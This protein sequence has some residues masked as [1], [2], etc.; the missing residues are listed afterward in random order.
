VS[1]L[2]IGALGSAATISPISGLGSAA[3]LAGSAA[4]TASSFGGALTQ[5]I[6]SLEQT[7]NTASTQEVALATGKTT[8]ESTVVADV[9]NAQLAMELASQITNKAVSSIQTIFGTQM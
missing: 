3:S 6:N 7:Q 4:P 9:E 2:P 1:V 5:A 8:D